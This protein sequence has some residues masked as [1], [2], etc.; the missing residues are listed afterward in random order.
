[1]GGGGAWEIVGGGGAG[2]GGQGGRGIAGMG[3][4]GGAECARGRMSGA[5]ATMVGCRHRIS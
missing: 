1:M 5:G 3:G 2:C 4:A